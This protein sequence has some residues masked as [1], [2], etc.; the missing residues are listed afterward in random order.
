MAAAAPCPQHTLQRFL[1]HPRL[2]DRDA[3]CHQK[4][5]EWADEEEAK[6]TTFY[7]FWKLTA[8]YAKGLREDNGP[9]RTSEREESHLER[10]GMSGGGG[11]CDLLG[12][13]EFLPRSKLSVQAQNTAP[14][15]PRC[16]QAE[17]AGGAHVVLQASRHAT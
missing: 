5:A 4:H 16:L 8:F 14:L 12:E 2:G 10:E 1:S 9:A 17:Q 13:L 7:S 6:T 11:T 3:G 15:P